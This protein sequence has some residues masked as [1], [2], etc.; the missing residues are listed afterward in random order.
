LDTVNPARPRRNTVD[1]STTGPSDSGYIK[2]VGKALAILK[3]LRA[4][5]HP[6]RITDVAEQL[7]LSQSVV[8]RIVAMLVADALVEQEPGTGHLHLGFGLTIL[9]NSAFGRRKLDYVALPIMSRLALQG[10]EYVSLS[11]LVQGRVVTVRGGPIHVMAHETFLS[12]V[13]PLHLTAPGK[14][15]ASSLDNQTIMKLLAESGM[16]PLTPNSIET[17]EAFIA[18]VEQARKQGYAIDNEELIVG[19]RHIATPIRDHEGRIIATLSAGG[20]AGHVQGAELDRL[21]NLIGTAS[22]QISRELGYRAPGPV[23]IRS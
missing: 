11:R 15:L 1:E 16:D 8:S 20:A 19:L 18:E 12:G 6:L 2:S 5:R 21:L 7:G 13:I 22:L 3:I 10:E 17:P 9:G 23:L 4:T 14:L